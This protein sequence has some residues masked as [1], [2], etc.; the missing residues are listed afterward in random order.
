[1]INYQ[2]KKRQERR[3][4]FSVFF[5]NNKWT[6]FGLNCSIVHF[7]FDMDYKSDEKNK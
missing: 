4:E 5:N 1:M 7:C 3:P 2:L 6:A